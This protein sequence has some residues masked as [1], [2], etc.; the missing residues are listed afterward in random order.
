MDPS[1][2]AQ[3]LSGSAVSVKIRDGASAVRLA[4]PCGPRESE[5]WAERP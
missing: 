4:G 3:N 5:P 1:V 2:S